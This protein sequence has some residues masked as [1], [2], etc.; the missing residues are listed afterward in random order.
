[1]KFQIG[2]KLKRT[3]KTVSDVVNGQIYTLQDITEYDEVNLVGIDGNYYADRFELYE[4]PP[5]EKFYK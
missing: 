1:M 2:D 3:G 4:R 5:K